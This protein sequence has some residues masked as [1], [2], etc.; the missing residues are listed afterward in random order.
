MTSVGSVSCNMQMMYCC[1]HITSLDV[2]RH[3]LVTSMHAWCLSGDVLCWSIDMHAASSEEHGK[4][5][6]YIY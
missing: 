6:H 3:T 4:Y 2:K 1:S 5:Q